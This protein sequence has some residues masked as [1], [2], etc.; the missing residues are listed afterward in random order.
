MEEIKRLRERKDERKTGEI[1]R[2]LRENIGDAGKQRK[3]GGN[4]GD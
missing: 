4:M 3:L 1:E 2:K